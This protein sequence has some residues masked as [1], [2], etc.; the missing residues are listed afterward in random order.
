VSL[1]LVSA[2]QAYFRDL[3]LDAMARQKVSA[4]PETECYLVQLLG[5]F[6]AAEKLTDAPLALMLKEAL[7]AQVPEAQAQKLKKVGDVSLYVAGYFQDSLF[8][9]LVD[10][11]Y[12]VDMGGRAYV[13]AAGRLPAQRPVFEELAGKFGKFVDVLADVGERTLPRDEKNLLR[14]YEL[15]LR[16]RSDR[17]ARQLSDAGIIPTDRA[18]DRSGKD[19]PH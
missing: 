8:G 6:V 10:V 5:Q 14:V 19:G 17:A 9:K 7:E 11:S 12:Y 16:T 18:G 3:V 2:P 4:T 1:E 13:S 15:W